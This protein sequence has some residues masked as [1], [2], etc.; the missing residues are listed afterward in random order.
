MKL[1]VAASNKNRL[2]LDEPSSIWF[3]KSIQW[4]TFTDFELVIADGGSDN[5]EELKE[6]FEQSEENIPMRIV[7]YKI[8][9]TFQRSLLNNV[10][11][12]NS[13][14]DYVMTTDVDML[15]E[16]T[17]M[18]TLMGLVDEKHL[19]ESRTLYLKP[20]MCTKIYSGVVDPS[21]DWDSCKCGRV[22][23]RTTAGGCQCMHKSGWDKVRGFDEQYMGWGSEDQDLLNRC[24]RA[25]LP[26][27]WMGEKPDRSNIKLFHQHHAKIDLRKD[28]ADQAKNKKR[29]NNIKHYRVNPNGWGGIED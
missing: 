24:R 14:G 2:I 12:R 13:N 19:I 3:L 17:F 26:A 20:T 23:K 25:G 18:E 4:Q 28:L 21:V 8:G 11:V 9:D 10:G 27:I 6:Y 5:Y 7:Q 29:L 16:S 22:K 1:T 15:F